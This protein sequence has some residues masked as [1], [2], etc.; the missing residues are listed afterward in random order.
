MPAIKNAVCAIYCR[1]STG[2][3]EAEGTSLASQE[4]ACR[5]YAVKHGYVV[6][7]AH[8]Y[9]EVH[10][11]AELWERPKLSA[12]RA[13][14]REREVGAIVA[15]AL[16]RLSR[17]QGHL[18][19]IDDECTRHDVA[20]LFATEEFEQ[21][22]IGKIIRSVKSFAA[23]LEREKIRE[24]TLRGK[25]TLAESGKLHNGGAE[26]YGYIRDKSTR[27]RTL[28][29]AE[30]V[31]VRRI[32]AWVGEERLSLYQVA[33]RL[34]GEG[35]PPPS[36]GKTRQ[37]PDAE[38]A[39]RWGK[40]Q[41]HRLLT[42]P[43]Y[44][45]ETY[46][47][48]YRRWT[49]NRELSRPQEEWLPLA[50]GTSPAIVSPALWQAA[51]D[52]LNTNTGAETRNENRAYL[53]RGHIYCAICGTRMYADVERGWRYYRCS[54]RSKAMGRCTGARV[55]ADAIEARVWEQLAAAIR[56][57][58]LIAA[59]WEAAKRAGPDPVLA[60]DRAAATR[61]LERLTKQ[62]ERL[63]RRL[64]DADDDVADLIE[65]EVGEIERERKS[66]RAA[67]AAIDARLAAQQQAIDQYGA[68]ADYCARV[69][70][71]LA[72]FDFEQKRLALRAFA[73]RV[74]ASGVEEVGPWRF[75]GSIPLEGNAGVASRSRSHSEQNTC[76]QPFR[77]VLAAPRAPKKS[78]LSQDKPDKPDN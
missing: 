65:R 39:P 17:E 43:A 36:V 61:S 6:D 4:A 62:Q 22:A 53:L 63:V 5:A 33:S 9:R 8:I 20:L 14:V 71:H 58:A 15:Y 75:T 66:V 45:G 12:L 73:I 19:I 25:R 23:E 31:V 72:E 2:A 70:A 10:T 29:E 74:E 35:I 30:A 55:P 51:Q 41:L 59:Q 57:P 27:T 76:S 11:G 1:V 56:D 68:L 67:M 49:K 40:S 52:R 38:Y 32:F 37:R 16:D 47:W 77:F 60:E 24:R 21:T 44:K 13:A 78:P 26:L 54:S 3:Q 48:R 34:N 18:Y 46:A 69:G 50:A 64:R 7:E 42:N 28:N